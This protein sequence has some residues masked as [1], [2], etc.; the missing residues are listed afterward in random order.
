MLV[1]D[2]SGQARRICPQDPGGLQFY[3][4]KGVGWAKTTSSFLGVVAPPWYL[5]SKSSA[6]WSL[7]SCPRSEP[8]C[9]PHPIPQPMTWGKYLA[10]T[11]QASLL[12]SDG[13]LEQLLI[14]SGLPKF[15][16]FPSL[17]MVPYWDLHNCLCLLHPY[18]LDFLWPQGFF[19]LQSYI[20]KTWPIFE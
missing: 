17:S 12:C 9:R 2:A 11:S 19:F 14:Y 1:R 6:E 5:V 15:P 7:N 3:H 18:Q 13:F 10:S 4:P 20:C 16:R 8:E